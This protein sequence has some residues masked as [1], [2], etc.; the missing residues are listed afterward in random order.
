MRR[1]GQCRGDLAISLGNLQQTSNTA[2]SKKLLFT[3][4]CAVLHS[5]FV[6]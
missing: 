3:S 1:E 5:R 6:G 4:T 2:E